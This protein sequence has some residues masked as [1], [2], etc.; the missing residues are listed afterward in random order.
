MIFMLGIVNRIE[1]NRIESLLLLLLASE[2]LNLHVN[3]EELNCTE[4]FQLN[5]VL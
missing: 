3:K 2:L 4:L 1:Q 5:S